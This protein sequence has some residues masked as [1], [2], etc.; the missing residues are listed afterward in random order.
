MKNI[1]RS[2]LI[3]I[4]TGIGSIVSCIILLVLILTRP[5]IADEVISLDDAT[6]AKCLNVLRAGLRSSEF[7]PSIHA[8]EALTLGGHGKEVIAFLEPLLDGPFDGQQR[9]GLAR[10][11]VRA[12]QRE[13]AKILLDI[14]AGEDSFGHT[15][16]AESLYKVGEL[17][18]GVA[19]R[20]RFAQDDDQRL[21]LMAAAALAKF[22]DASALM[23]IR[24]MV[25]HKDPE[26]ARTAAW[27]IGRVGD[28]SDI[29]RLHG[30]YE[31]MPDELSRCYF[32]HS[33]AVLGGQFGRVALIRNLGSEDAAVRTYAAT[34][35]GDGRLTDAEEE[36]KSM[37][38]DEVLDVRVRAAQTLLVLTQEPPDSA[39]FAVLPNAREYF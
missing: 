34:F 4:R 31:A 8:A 22:G 1:A 11:L 35:A 16:A 28:S 15:H 32:E 30:A 2:S 17:G 6:R 12:G 5:V 26:L 27:I 18:D 25:N 24:K 19:M 29:E 38:D 3:D 10:E 14:L 33:A 13:H 39:S 21:K 7:W 37:L 23:H 9:C 20:K 36:L